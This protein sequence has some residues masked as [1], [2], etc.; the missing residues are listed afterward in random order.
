MLLTVRCELLH[1]VLVILYTASGNLVEAVLLENMEGLYSDLC[2]FG[3]VLTEL[4][5]IVPVYGDNGLRKLLDEFYRFKPG[6][7]ELFCDMKRTGVPIAVRSKDPCVR[8]EVLSALLRE[9][10]VFVKVIRPTVQ[11]MEFRTNR[12][13][14]TI[15]ALDSATEA[16]RAYV[17]CRLVSRASGVGKLLQTL[18]MVL[19]GVIAALLLMLGRAPSAFAVTMWLVAWCALYVI[20]SYSLLED[21]SSKKK[22]KISRKR[23]T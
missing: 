3:K 19:G 7:V 5:E 14:A 12:V 8:E 15:V 13:D 4:G 11:E 9:Q 2:E 16:A 21:R 18:S 10:G 23:S 22:H 1:I 6:V 20:A 17:C